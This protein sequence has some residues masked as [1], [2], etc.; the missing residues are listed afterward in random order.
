VVVRQ[1][2]ETAKGITFMLLEDEFGL[3][4]VVVYPGLYERQRREVRA[5]SLLMVEGKLQL[6][7][8]N[9]NIVAIRF[10]Q[11]GS[12]AFP[13]GMDDVPPDDPNGLRQEADPRTIQFVRDGG[14]WPEG[15]LVEAVIDLSALAPKAHTYR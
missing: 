13:E 15:R 1:R 2:P 14:Q 12:A 4:N 9:I 8:N 11:I 5:V 10:Q 7:N 6:A 3:V